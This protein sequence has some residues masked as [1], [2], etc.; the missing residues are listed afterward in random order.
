M[1]HR[2][3]PARQARG[4]RVRV[5]QIGCGNF[6]PAHLAGW[7]RLGLADSLTVADPRPDLAETL[8][9]HAPG[10]R[11]V[12]DWRAAL[13]DADLVDVLT[14]TDTHHAIAAA[15]LDA[16]KPLFLEKPAAPTADE[17]RDLLRRAEAAAVPVQVGM[18]L[19]FHPKGAALKALVEEG[20]VGRLLHLSARFLGIKRMR[21]D[22]GPLAND[23]VHFIDLILWLVGDVP[24]RVF[25]TLRD[26]EGRG[27][28]DLAAVQMRFASGAT[29]LVE[30]GYRLPGATSDPF[31]P[32]T[33]STKE[34]VVTGT[35]GVVR[36]SLG[37][38]R[39]TLWRG[40]HRRAGAILVPDYAEPEDIAAPAADPPEVMARQFD[41]LLRVLRGE[42]APVA[43]LRDAGVAVARVLDAARE[44]SRT[45][46]V[47][48]LA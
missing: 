35:E 16:G 8:A 10:A 1:V 5:L 13:A 25:A 40:R 3:E 23:A 4:K 11:A 9:R 42:A 36:F 34:L 44:A 37:E 2:I 7:A 43:T 28:D 18:Y 31:V 19:R 14:P 29:A 21:A 6:G 22:S 26:D 12:A 46:A 20:A 24:S 39:L 32:G 30:A 27:H 48:A 38:E 41:H 47:V 45:G 33:F 17:A 15:V